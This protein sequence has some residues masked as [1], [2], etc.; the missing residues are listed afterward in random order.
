MTV[1]VREDSIREQRRDSI[2]ENREA[3]GPLLVL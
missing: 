3:S 2:G 1:E